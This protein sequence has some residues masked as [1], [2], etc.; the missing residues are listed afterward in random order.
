MKG[1]R[2]WKSLGWIVESYKASLI[3]FFLAFSGVMLIQLYLNLDN[4][5]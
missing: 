5:A 3:A 2:R 4:V 1:S